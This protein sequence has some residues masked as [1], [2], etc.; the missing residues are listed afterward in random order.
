MTLKNILFGLAAGA[1]LFL[2][3]AE[4]LHAQAQPRNEQERVIVD[5]EMRNRYGEDYGY[6][7]RESGEIKPVN[8]A[9][10]PFFGMTWVASYILMKK[11]NRRQ[12]R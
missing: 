10:D 3:T 6:C 9:M 12:G 1:G 4:N 2:A 8:P 11:I 7:Y 5:K